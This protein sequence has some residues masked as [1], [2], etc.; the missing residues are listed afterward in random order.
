M[1]YHYSD[2][3]E[4]ESLGTKDYISSDLDA[5]A[6]NSW[7][8]DPVI[9]NAMNKEFDFGLDAAANDQNH[10]CF[11]YLTKED[12]SLSKNWSEITSR[13]VW[14]NPPY[15]KGFIKAFMQKCI[16]QK[17]LG[18]TSVLLVPATLDAQW[19]P[20]DQISEIRIVTGGRLSFYHPETNKK[21][22]GNTKGSMF[23]I[24]RPSKMPCVVRMVDRNELLAL[25]TIKTESCFSCSKDFVPDDNNDRAEGWFCNEC[26]V[27]KG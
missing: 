27:N 7:G 9:F 12:D 4:K 26:L 1:T 19:L 13:T 10:K 20:I 15:G 23:V 16:E 17:E 5:D 2:N 6:K 25:G 3:Y 18:V 21:I 24:F 11:L 8:T 14:I 22:N